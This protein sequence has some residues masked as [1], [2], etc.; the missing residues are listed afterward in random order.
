MGK[1]AL[2]EPVAAPL[3][4]VVPDVAQASQHV[5]GSPELLNLLSPGN[6]ILPSST[7]TSGLEESIWQPMIEALALSGVATSA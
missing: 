7:D 1:S 5:Q 6:F 3:H 2:E 4:K